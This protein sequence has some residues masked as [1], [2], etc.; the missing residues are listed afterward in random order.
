MLSVPAFSDTVYFQNGT[1]ISGKIKNQNIYE[2]QLETEPGKIQI[3][4]KN[5]VSRVS[6]EEYVARKTEPPPAKKEEPPKTDPEP[7]VYQVKKD[8]KT[9]LIDVDMGHLP[10][11]FVAT[12]VRGELIIP[13][14]VRNATDKYFLLVVNPDLL[15][16]GDY[17]LVIRSIDGKEISR[18]TNFVSVVL[19]ED[20]KVVEQ[21]QP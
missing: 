3:I 21:K 18:K 9:Y 17:D 2:I 4:S 13:Q 10:L 19:P 1:N 12:L 20:P 14:E 15:L 11:I 7:M 6:Y 8:N 5:L 16:T